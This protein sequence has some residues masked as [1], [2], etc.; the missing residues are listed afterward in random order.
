MKKKLLG[1]SNSNSKKA[2]RNAK[3]TRKAQKKQN[4]AQRKLNLN[5]A[6]TQRGINKQV[7]K[8]NT[9]ATFTTKTA[10]TKS[11]LGKYM[12][13]C[14]L[15]QE[16]YDSKHEEVR[17]G[18]NK[19]EQIKDKINTLSDDILSHIRGIQE[20]NNVSDNSNSESNNDYMG[21]DIGDNSAEFLRLLEEILNQI[22]NDSQISSDVAKLDRLINEQKEMTTSR[23][24]N[25]SEIDQKLGLIEGKINQIKGLSS[26]PPPPGGGGGGGGRAAASTP[27]AQAVG[28]SLSRPAA[29]RGLSTRRPAT[30]RNTNKRPPWKL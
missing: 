23:T 5:A 19:I 8:T 9:L 29:T 10:D 28:A 26:L 3:R 6:R 2:Q 7:Q 12:D 22:P 30:R 11:Q 18:T 16:K 1:G 20:L 15:L 14:S 25:K 27:R 24:Q 13:Y 17:D 4:K 21:N